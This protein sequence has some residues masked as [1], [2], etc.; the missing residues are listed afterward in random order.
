MRKRNLN[1]KY[2]AAA[3]AAVLLAAA[4]TACGT[5]ASSGNSSAASAAQTSQITQNTQ[6]EQSSGEQYT[7]T[8]DNSSSDA[9]LDTES[10]FTDRDLTQT[11]DL[12]EAEY[13]TVKDGE[14]VTITSE[15]TYVFTGT[16]SDA[17]II[18]EAG[19]EDKVQLVLD[20]VSISNKDFPCIYVKNADKVFVTTTDTENSLFVI[21]TFTDDGT[22]NT[23]AVIF[24]KDGLVLNG[25]GTLNISSSD[26]GISCKDDLKITG[27]TYYISSQSDALEA[28]DSVY[29]EDGVIVIK[30]GEDGVHV[31]NDEDD[32]VGNF[33]MGGGSLTITAGDDAVHATTI[34]Q[35]DG[36]E[37]NISAAEGLEATWVQINDGTISIT[38]SDDGINGAYKSSAYTPTI[39]INGGTITIDIG[40]GDT[41]AVDSNGNLYINGGTLD[42]TARSAFDYDGTAEYNGGTIIVNGVQVNSITNQMMGGMGMQ[43]GGFGGQPGDFG[44]QGGFGQQG[45]TQP[46]GNTGFG[47]RR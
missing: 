11:A 6:T 22:T 33:Y 34:L 21:G 42:I 46:G 37:I 44:G 2:L 27:G 31:E 19:D 10:L 8:S 40:A 43:Q 3:T 30:T 18:V 9:A 4:L 28:N 1:G 7:G 17:T 20:G 35:I 47:P 32:T 29:M 24:S 45:G 14:N 26:N 23:D 41:D 16:A 13:I 38:A 25:T 39:E 5:A 15:G 36:G 12:S